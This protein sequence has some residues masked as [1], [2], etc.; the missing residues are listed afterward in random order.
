[1]LKNAWKKITQFRRGG[2]ERGNIFRNVIQTRSILVLWG[3]GWGTYASF[4]PPR[5]AND[6]PT[7][8][9]QGYSTLL[10][11]L[12]AIVFNVFMLLM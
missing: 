1:M 8:N 2:N 3:W 5:S 9:H 4:A 6:S 10:E 11:T 7:H 12:L